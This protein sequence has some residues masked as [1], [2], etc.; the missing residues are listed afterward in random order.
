MDL[1]VE[2]P[3]DELGAIAT[4]AMWKEIY[5]RIATLANEHQ[6]TLVFV[7][8]RRLAER[9]GHH[10]AEHL[11]DDAVATHH[12]SLS[13]SIRLTVEEQLKRGQIRVV[14]ATASLELGID[15][16]TVDLVLSDWIHA[17]HRD[18]SPTCRTIQAHG[19]R[20]SKRTIVCNHTR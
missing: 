2:V 15:I 8:T 6:S 11:G 1:A 14:V 9:V 5:A 3:K 17:S 13:Q 16:G 20:D 7:N 12:G 10:L 19:G 18:V 4:N